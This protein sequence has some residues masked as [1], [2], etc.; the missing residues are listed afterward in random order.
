MFKFIYSDKTGA[1]WITFGFK[2][3]RHFGEIIGV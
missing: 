1:K 2:Y 3:S